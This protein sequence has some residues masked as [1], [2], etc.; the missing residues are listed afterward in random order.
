VRLDVQ[1]LD[2]PS[3][4]ESSLEAIRPACEAKGLRLQCVLDPLA[5]PVLGDPS[6]L[7]QVLWNLLSNSVKFTGKQ[8]RIQVALERVNSHIELSV[9]DSGQGIK[10]EFLPHVFDRFQQADSSTTRRYGGLGLGLAIVRHLVE[11]HGGTVRALSP[12]EGQGAT[13]IVSLPIMVVDPGDDESQRLHPS[14]SVESAAVFC[15]PSLKGLRVLVV[16]DQ[17]DALQLMQHLLEQCECTVLTA[18]S[19]TQGLEAVVH[20]KP[21]V[22]ISDI[23]M[24]DLDGYEFM[25]RLRALPGEARNTPAIALSAFA[26]SEDRR[27]AMLAGFQLHLAKP[28]EFP[29]LVAA[30]A[31]VSG[32]TRRSEGSG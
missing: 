12:G 8:G 21:H 26:R 11:L 24:P 6:R 32:L 22:V 2:L 27:R 5:G 14:A 19:T 4:I 7:Q 10:P 28:V 16:D 15:P 30:I 23:G 18:D 1:R 29:E 13:F 20:D 25:R 3:V 17:H 9:S 31:N